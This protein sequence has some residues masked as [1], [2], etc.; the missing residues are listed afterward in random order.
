MEN[1]RPG[2]NRKKLSIEEKSMAIGWRQ[3]NISN[4][5]ISRRL[6]C[7]KDAIGRLFAKTVGKPKNFVPPRAKGS[8]RP[9]KFTEDVLKDIKYTISREP[10]LTAGELKKLMPSLA[11]TAERSVQHALLKYLEMPS[12]VMAMK[13]LLT[14]KMKMKRLNFAKKYAHWTPED[15]SKV[16]YSDESTFRCVRNIRK[17]VRRPSGSNRFDTKYT[18]KTVKHPASVMIWGCFSANLGRGGIFFLPKNVTMNSERYEQVLK[19]KLLPFMGMHNTEYFLQD[20]APCHAAKR[21]KKFLETNNIKTID[22]PG[23]SPDLNPIENC[24]AH[25]K[26]MVAKKDVGSVPKLSEA[27]KEVW[28]SELTPE[29]LKKLSDSMPDRLKAVI[30]AKGDTTKY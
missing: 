22:W 3:E 5:E 17:M 21:I 15:W 9:R 13:P 12:R 2:K 11:D 1:Q 25:M 8:G 6:G 20:G 18:A 10:T 16:M 27:I 7:G 23:N 19:E 28:I 14:P 4:S 26:N 24:W 30:A 29:Y